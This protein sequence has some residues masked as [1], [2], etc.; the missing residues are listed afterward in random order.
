M[1][2]QQDEDLSSEE[3]SNKWDDTDTAI[4]GYVIIMIASVLQALTALSNRAMKEIE[5]PVIGFWYFVGGL[6]GS[7]VYLA[8]EATIMGKLR[9]SE[10]T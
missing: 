3:E 5:T 9:M 4:T 1:Q 6:S 2:R 10:Y 7:I 8:C